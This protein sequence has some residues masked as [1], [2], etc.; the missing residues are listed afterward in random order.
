M[1]AA[2]SQTLH[3]SAWTHHSR[4]ATTQPTDSNL[5]PPPMH[6]HKD[7][8]QNTLQHDG[9]ITYGNTWL[10]VWEL[11]YYYISHCYL[12][13]TYLPIYITWRCL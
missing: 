13:Y 1:L 6:I 4:N 2:G 5:Q 11:W 8:R 9:Q 3:R 12:Y 7:Y 10:Q